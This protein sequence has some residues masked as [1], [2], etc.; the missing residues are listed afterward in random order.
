MYPIPICLAH[1]MLR[2]SFDF[3]G[4]AR[5][6][7]F[8]L[9]WCMCGAARRAVEGCD[10]VRPL[11]RVE[12]PSRPDRAQLLIGDFFHLDSGNQRRE[13]FRTYRPGRREIPSFRTLPGLRLANDGLGPY[14]WFCGPPL[15]K[16]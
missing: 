9:D 15:R 10:I 14:I 6:A 5:G 4:L 11:F 13:L 8:F 3:P 2:L 1:V 7:R 16:S 12:E